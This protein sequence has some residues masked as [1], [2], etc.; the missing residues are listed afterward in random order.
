MSSQNG[1]RTDTLLNSLRST[2][3][4]DLPNMVVALKGL[5]QMLEREEKGRLS[6]SGQEYLARLFRVSHRLQNALTT[7][8]SINKVQEGAALPEAVR[9]A[10]LVRAGRGRKIRG[11]LR[12]RRR[13]TDRIHVGGTFEVEAGERVLL[14]DPAPHLE[15]HEALLD[16]AGRLGRSQLV[17]ALAAAKPRPFT[18]EWLPQQEVLGR[19]ARPRGGAHVVQGPP[20]SGK[21]WLIAQ[22]ALQRQQWQV[23]DTTLRHIWM[24][25]R[26]A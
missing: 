18:P 9:L 2:I 10:E 16:A 15:P 5:L 26:T 19:L 4:H 13:E 21:T 25:A 11:P 8:R 14:L 17:A 12:C 3:N 1:A 22:L 24:K 20:G 7:M 6:P 23:V